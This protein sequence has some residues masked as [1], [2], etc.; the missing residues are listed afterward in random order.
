[1]N[2]QQVRNALKRQ[3][4]LLKKDRLHSFNGNHLGGYNIIDKETN[5]AIGGGNYA[6][7]LEQIVEWM[8]DGGLRDAR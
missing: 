3:G 2:E 6:W 4:F 1:M 8:M 5:C 7:D